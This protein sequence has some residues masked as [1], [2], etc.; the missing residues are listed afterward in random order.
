MEVKSNNWIH[1]IYKLEL[2]GKFIKFLC[3]LIR[4][5]KL[6]QILSS[7]NQNNQF[8]KTMRNMDGTYLKNLPKTCS[9]QKTILSKTTNSSKNGKKKDLFMYGIFNRTKN[10]T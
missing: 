10:V 9:L 7:I 5:F 8:L 4:I 3:S 6:L 1:L 2:K